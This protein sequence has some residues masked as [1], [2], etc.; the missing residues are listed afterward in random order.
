MLTDLELLQL[1]Y[2]TAIKTSDDPSTQTGSILVDPHT[3]EPISKFA[4]TFPIGVTVKDER[5]Q[6]PLKYDYMVHAEMGSIIQCAKDGIKTQGAIMYAPWFACTMCARIIING[7]ISEVV[8]HDH[9]IYNDHP[10]WNE[11]VKL[12]LD[13][14]REA[15]IKTRWIKGKIGCEILMQGKLEKI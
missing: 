8:G 9:P 3:R 13:M 1:A 12:G 14:I 11:Q 2:T 6:R 15:G 7:G 5:L 10:S 4:N